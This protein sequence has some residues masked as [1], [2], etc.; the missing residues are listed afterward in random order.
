[1]K[2]L[3]SSVNVMDLAISVICQSLSEFSP[4]LFKVLKNSSSNDE[5]QRPWAHNSTS[6]AREIELRLQQ[7]IFSMTGVAVMNA[8]AERQQ[9]R[10]VW[11]LRD[12]GSGLDLHQGPDPEMSS[13]ICCRLSDLAVHV[14]VSHCFSLPPDRNNGFKIS[15]HCPCCTFVPSNNYIIPNKSEE[16]E[17]RFAGGF[18]WGCESVSLCVCVC[19]LGEKRKKV[20]SPSDLIYIYIYL[21]DLIKAWIAANQ[22]KTK[23]T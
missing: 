11:L 3:R 6:P 19:V 4:W 2:H 17:A 20:L 8:G 23:C 1:M 18:G 5:G 16:L 12:D 22:F 10:C 14:C 9:W 21:L 15:L 13:F 7:Q